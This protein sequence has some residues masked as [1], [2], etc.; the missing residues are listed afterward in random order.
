[1]IVHS[2]TVTRAS[3]GAEADYWFGLASGEKRDP[4]WMTRIPDVVRSATIEA[5]DTAL[6]GRKATLTFGVSIDPG[7][8]DAVVF[9]AKAL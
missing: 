3:L 7:N 6:A 2:H 4:Q 8:P 1:M 9:R 5:R